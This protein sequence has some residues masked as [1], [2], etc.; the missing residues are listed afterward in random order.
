MDESKPM[1]T[2]MHLSIAFT[3]NESG[4]LGDQMIYKVFVNVLDFDLILIHLNNMLLFTTLMVKYQL[5]DYSS[6]EHNILIFCN[7][8]TSIKLSKNLIQHLRENISFVIM[9]KKVG[10]LESFLEIREERARKLG[11]RYPLANIECRRRRRS[12]TFY[13]YN[14]EEYSAQNLFVEE[15]TIFASLEECI[16][17]IA[18]FKF[19]KKEIAFVRESLYASCE[20]GFFDYL[21]GVDCFDVEVSRYDKWTHSNKVCLI[22]IKYTMEKTIKDNIHDIENAKEFFNAIGEK[23]KMFN[24]AKKAQNLSLL[25]KTTYDGVGGVYEHV[26][27]M[28]N[29]YNKLKSMKMELG[30]D[31]LI[32]QVFESL[33]PQFDFLRTSYNAQQNVE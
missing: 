26:M 17:F 14:N 11:F 30:E 24:K 13:N 4:K 28:V 33:P 1:S 8:A 5:E 9:F 25:V 29:W 23:F 21:R 20:D 2:L 22:I 15:Y 18:N 27:K 7:N 10:E 19:T 12:Q 3:K 32:W 31:F 16:R 6:F